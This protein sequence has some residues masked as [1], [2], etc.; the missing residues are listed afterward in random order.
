MTRFSA[1]SLVAALMLLAGCATTPSEPAK[2]AS[3]VVVA[4]KPVEPAKPAEP[5]AITPAPSTKPAEIIKQVEPTQPATATAPIVGNWEG[6][7]TIDSM[8]YEGKTVIVIE[9][10]DGA[11]V[12][13]R[14]TM[15]DTPYG[16][17][18]EAFAPATF[19][20]S[21]LNVKHQNNA[22]YVL[23]LGEKDGAMRLSGPLV[24]ITEAGTYNGNIRVS[25]K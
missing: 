12:V 23:T 21:K 16:D 11:N 8:G 25:K 24:Y 9:K 17:L 19:D 10:L 5:A 7:W 14:A 3:P 6:K 4:P 2:P 22:S 20:G 13:G 15:F 18:T 1:Y